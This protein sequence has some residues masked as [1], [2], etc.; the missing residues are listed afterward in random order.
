MAMAKW[1]GHGRAPETSCDTN[2]DETPMRRARAA[3]LPH[4]EHAVEMNVDMVP[5]KHSFT[6]AVKVCMLSVQCRV[7][8]NEAMLTSGPAFGAYLKRLATARRVSNTKLADAA[9][10]SLQ[11]VTGWFKTGRIGRS[12]LVAI[13]PLLGTSVDALLRTEEGAQHAAARINENV[14][15]IPVVGELNGSADGHIEQHGYPRGAEP[16]RVILCSFD[17]NAYALRVRGDAMQPRYDP[18]DYVIIEPTRVPEPGDVVLV[19]LR[20]GRTLL[21]KL[22]YQRNGDLA[23]GSINDS[24]RPIT[25]A[26]TDIEER[27][28]QFVAGSV[29]GRSCSVKEALQEA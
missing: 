13:A 18:G 23:L 19:R 29:S 24:Y 6:P 5:I 2:A 4:K 10:T 15:S 27:G 14:R 11:S 16:T 12:S 3:W 1:G 21:K 20:D 17:A 22:L 26:L 28:I 8:H 25:V 9:G 7:E